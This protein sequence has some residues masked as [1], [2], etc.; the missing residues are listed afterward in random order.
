MVSLAAL[1]SEARI[2]GRGLPVA[3]P[4]RCS[5]MMPCSASAAAGAAT[6]GPERGS[7]ESGL[8]RPGRAGPV[9]FVSGRS[10]STPAAA[11]SHAGTRS[12]RPARPSSPRSLGSCGQA[13][14]RQVARHRVGLVETMG[15]GAAGMDGNACVVTI[16]SAHD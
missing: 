5:T 11:C 2:R 16:L 7:V 12:A 15:G 10:R 3:D 6:G 14:A 8:L 9:R 4:R 1:L 13:Y